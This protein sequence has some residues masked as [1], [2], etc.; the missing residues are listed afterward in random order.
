[1][2]LGGSY[3]VLIVGTYG[4]CLHFVLNNSREFPGD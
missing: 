1:V 3:C 4:H 2:D